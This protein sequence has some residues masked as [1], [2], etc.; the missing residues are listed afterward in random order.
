MP[1]PCH[2]HSA[3][4]MS[5]RSLV[6]LGERVVDRAQVLPRG[7]DG[8]RE[9][10]VRDGLG[11]DDREAGLEVEVD[12]AVEEPRAGVVRGEPDRDVVARGGYARRDDVAPDRVV[13]VVRRRACAADDREGVLEGDGS[14]E[15]RDV[16]DL[17]ESVSGRRVGDLHRAGGAGEG[18]RRRWPWRA[19]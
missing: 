5:T 15:G 16:S 12:V 19:W 17:R 6:G 7:R 3:P 2:G 18:R 9:L 11:E 4:S 1:I 10:R 13:V 8:V 14:Y